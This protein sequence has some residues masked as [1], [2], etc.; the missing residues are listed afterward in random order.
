MSGFS[1]NEAFEAK[2]SGTAEVSDSAV[3]HEQD[4]IRK[5]AVEALIALGYSSTE[6]LR[7][8]SSVQDAPDVESLLK[9]ALRKF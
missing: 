3:R 5:E 2:L 1:L 4:E 9:A 6:A 8:V 7:A